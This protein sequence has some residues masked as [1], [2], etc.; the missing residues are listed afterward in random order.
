MRA[1]HPNHPDDVRHYD[2]QEIRDKFLMENV[3]EADQVI[4]GYT[5]F[6][7]MV[8]GGIMPATKELSINADIDYLVTD[9]FCQRREVGIIN[10][11][12]GSANIVADGQS[13]TLNNQDA[14][15]IG[16]GTKEI[17][18]KAVDSANPPKLYMASTPA[19]HAYPTTIVT[20]DKA[21]KVHLGSEETAN[22]RTINQYIVP[23]IVEACQLVMGMTNFEP[24]S[25]WNTMPAHTHD[26]RM[27]V[28]LYFNMEEN[29]K[30]FHFMGE[31]TET[32]HIV[33]SNEQ[34][35]I[36]PSWSIHSGCG[37][38]QYSFI[39]AMGG[40]NMLF[41]DMDHIAMGDLR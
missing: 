15:Y 14:I 18:F 40:E 5:H 1:Y 9:F 29:T 31:P 28:Y 19:H 7:R 26:R 4:L 34:A 36:S 27:E 24:G 17:T 37:T 38:G 21:N 33:M 13:Y 8:F 39:W 3:F 11:G 2:T 6:D 35:V 20:L 32:R 41:T 22:K 12:G 23:G 30:V 25:V 16:M 10:I